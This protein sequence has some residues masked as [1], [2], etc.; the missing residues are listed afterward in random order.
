MLPSQR[1]TSANGQCIGLWLWRQLAG[2]EL[3]WSMIVIVVCQTSPA[4]GPLWLWHRAED[5]PRPDPVPAPSPAPHTEGEGESG[6]VGPV[7]I[8]ATARGGY[9]P[10]PVITSATNLHTS[11]NT[12][13]LSFLALMWSLFSDL[14]TQLGWWL[15]MTGSP[16][17]EQAESWPALVGVTGTRDTRENREAGTGLTRPGQC[18]SDWRQWSVITQPHLLMEWPWGSGGGHWSLVSMHR[19]LSDVMT[20]R[21]CEWAKSSLSQDYAWSSE[22]CQEIGYSNVIIAQWSR[23]G[24]PLLSDY[25]PNT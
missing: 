24:S 11:I 19:E 20:P 25:H 13:D 1:R 10:L 17:C 18:W 14:V 21:G 16:L 8:E 12:H 23:V 5:T 9:T 6:R 15:M 7:V 3:I 4:P 2:I 22:L